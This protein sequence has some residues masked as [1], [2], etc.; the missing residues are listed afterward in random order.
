MVLSVYFDV[1]EQLPIPTLKRLIWTLLKVPA[2]PY[3]N[4]TTNS[5]GLMLFYHRFSLEPRELEAG[6]FRFLVNWKKK[7]LKKRSRRERRRRRRR[8]MCGTSCMLSGI[9]V[10]GAEQAEWWGTGSLTEP[11]R[12]SRHQAR[13]ARKTNLLQICPSVAVFVYICLCFSFSSPLHWWLL[14]SNVI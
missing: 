14:L 1:R 9:Q 13:Q 10:Q 7:R 12:L 8:E 4:T 5:S 3:L 11:T 2:S 6:T